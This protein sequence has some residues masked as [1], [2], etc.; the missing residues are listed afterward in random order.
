MFCVIAVMKWLTVFFL[1]VSTHVLSQNEDV[2]EAFS[3]SEFN[4]KVLLAFSITQGNTC[5]GVEIFRSTDSLN[6]TKV[7][8]IEGICGSTQETIKYEF[9]DSDPVI[10]NVN[11]YRL[12]LGGFGYSW[13]VSTEVIDVSGADYLLNPNPVTYTSELNF[14]NES[15]DLITLKVFALSGELVHSESTIGEQFVLNR[16][17][18]N[19][20]LYLFH[21]IPQSGMDVI[22]GKFVVF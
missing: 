21:L 5:N 3:A 8:S 13:V 10:N 7:G 14:D 2:I 16:L 20:G 17:D 6:Y 22:S 1:I 4:N 18:Y 12:L 15:N 9:T 11:Y 19:S